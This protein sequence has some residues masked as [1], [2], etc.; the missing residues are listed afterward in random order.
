LEITLVIREVSSNSL[1]FCSNT[2][3]GELCYTATGA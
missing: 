1:Q 3:K 2:V